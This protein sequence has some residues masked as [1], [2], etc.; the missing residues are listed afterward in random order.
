V[1]TLGNI[2]STTEYQG[3]Q[4]RLPLA[5]G[6][7]ETGKPLVADLAKM[8]HLLIAGATGSGKSVCLNNVVISLLICNAETDLLLIDTKRVELSVY[9]SLANVCHVYEIALAKQMLHLATLRMEYKY[10]ELQYKAVRNI[11]VYNAKF[12]PQMVYNIVVIDE[13][14]DLIL[15]DKAIEA[16]VVRLAQMG[17]AAGIHLVL[18]TQRPTVN[19][20]TGLIKAN[21]PARIAFPVTTAVDSR[22]ILDRTGAENLE[23]PGDMIYSFGRDYVK[24]R[25]AYVLPRQIENFVRILKG[26]GK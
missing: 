25:G 7:A 13:F 23:N 19:V 15:Q 11:Q 9:T 8:P 17:R 4:R 18:A 5:L 14:A 6:I 2:L 22:V 26:K 3:N 24:A 20:V 10:Q 12:T 21:F 1:P 16:Y